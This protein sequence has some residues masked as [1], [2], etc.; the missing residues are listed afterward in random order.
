MLKV[1]AWLIWIITFKSN[2][3]NLGIRILPAIICVSGKSSELLG[4]ISASLPALLLII[5]GGQ[6]TKLWEIQKIHLVFLSYFLNSKQRCKKTPRSAVVTGWGRT[7]ERSRPAS[8]L[9][10]VSVSW[11]LTIPSSHLTILNSHLPF[12]VYIEPFWI[13][14]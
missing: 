13:H 8:V 14:I 7:S 6:V 4:H 5:I 1:G 12:W 11:Y 9:R 3:K 10:E 2:K